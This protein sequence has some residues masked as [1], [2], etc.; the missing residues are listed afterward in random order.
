MKATQLLAQETEINP[1]ENYEE[2][3][4]NLT[5]SGRYKGVFLTSA[6]FINW[7]EKVEK[8]SNKIGE[9]KLLGLN[10]SAVNTTVKASSLVEISLEDRNRTFRA[11]ERTDA[12]GIE[13][14]IL[15]SVDSRTIDACPFDNLA[16]RVYVGDYN[17]TAR[18][19]PVFEPSTASGVSGA[20]QKILVTKDV[21]KYTA[22]EVRDFA[23]YFSELKPASPGNYN[24]NYV[25]DTS[26]TPE[27]SDF[28]Q[29]Q[30]A[31]IHQGLWKSNFARVRNSEC[32]LPASL[33][34]VPSIADRVENKT[35]GTNP[36]GVFTLLNPS[37]GS[38][39]GYERVDPSGVNPVKVQ[40]VSTGS[41]ETWPQ[42]S[43]GE[44]LVDSLGL[45][46]LK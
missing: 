1:V 12:Y 17:G 20:G 28:E 44:E 14:P 36:N 16:E 22:S 31:I 30:R 13:D 9:V 29:N 24:S 8:L 4:E 37:S 6:N 5:E 32:Y 15:A 3:A 10:V 11:V 43:M 25:T 19:I 34:R 39:V 38:D 41:G 21:T 18:G 35:R 2:A 45:S 23:G 33:D 7:S 42:F 27:N 40:G 26:S 46:V